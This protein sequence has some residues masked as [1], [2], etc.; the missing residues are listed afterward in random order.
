M[1]GTVKALLRKELLLERRAPTVV[2]AMLLFSV[3]TFVLFHFALQQNS[4]DGALASG[5]LWVTLLF[6]AILGAGRLF[7]V[8]EE[9]GGFDAFLLAP[10]DRTAMLIAKGATFLTFLVCVEV[11]AVPTFIVLLLGPGLGAGDLAK[12]AGIMALADV[13]VV[14]AGTLVASLAV[15]TRARDLLV[16]LIALPLLVPVMIGAA[17]ATTPLLVTGVTGALPGRYLTILGLY[18]L[19][20][21]LIAFAVFDYLLDD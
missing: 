15:R 18:D 8:D 19:V 14:T 4:V 9:E 13:G 10:V 17:K 7:A 3:S 21:A 16:P 11:V 6:A 5:T 1:S 20:F 12:L 2:P